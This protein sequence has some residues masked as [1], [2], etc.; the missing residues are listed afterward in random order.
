MTEI[1]IM[2][3]VANNPRV[4][5]YRKAIQIMHRK[6]T[7]VY[8]ADYACAPILE[9]TSKDSRRRESPIGHTRMTDADWQRFES[10]LRGAA[11]VRQSVRESLLGA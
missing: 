6:M 11:L 9:S 5:Q 1:Q 3:A 4:V 7:S 8:G 10:L 2:L